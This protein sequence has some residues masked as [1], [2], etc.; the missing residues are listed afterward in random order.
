MIQGKGEF[1]ER[2]RCNSLLQSGEGYEVSNAAALFFFSPQFFQH[3]K[4][5]E[6]RNIAGD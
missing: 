2:F 5:L 3:R 6:R 1:A 4:I